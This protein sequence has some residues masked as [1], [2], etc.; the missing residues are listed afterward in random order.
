MGEDDYLASIA[1][2]AGSFAPVGWADCNGA[3][4]DINRNSA[5]FSLIGV[6]YGG[7]GRMNFALPD[8]RPKDDQ[9]APRQWRPGELRHCIC[10]L[11]RYPIR[12]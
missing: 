10:T 9:G 4:L 1:L 11:G 2:F 12:P 6:A 8:L 3:L 5:L 7:D